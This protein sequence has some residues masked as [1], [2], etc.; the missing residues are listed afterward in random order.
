MSLLSYGEIGYLE[1]VRVSVCLF[2]SRQPSSIFFYLFIFFP[3]FICFGDG[4]APE[5]QHPFPAVLSLNPSGAAVNLESKP[6]ICPHPA[7]PGH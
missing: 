3:P 2:D 7:F 5:I 6:S 1:T 4:Q